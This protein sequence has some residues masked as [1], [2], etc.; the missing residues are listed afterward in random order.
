MDKI[1][2]E[3]RRRKMKMRRGCRDKKIVTAHF[4]PF[5]LH[6]LMKLAKKCFTKHRLFLLKSP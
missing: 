6:F 4:M 5:Y 1:T 3:M 2:H